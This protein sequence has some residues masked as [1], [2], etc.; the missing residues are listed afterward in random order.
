MRRQ[1]DENLARARVA[2]AVQIQ[3]V[4][5]SFVSRSV[6]AREQKATKNAIFLVQARVS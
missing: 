4:I 2:A 6:N 1:R 5:R 3:C